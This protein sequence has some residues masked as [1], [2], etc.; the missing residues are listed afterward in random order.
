MNLY[1]TVFFL[2]MLTFFPVGSG[3]FIGETFGAF[4]ALGLTSLI[5]LGAYGFSD[6]VVLYLYNAK[7]LNE[8]EAQELFD[9]VKNLA[10][11]GGI[12]T[13]KV[14]L[15]NHATPNTFSTGR[16]P[17]HGSLIFTT[18]LLDLLN[19]KELSGI[20]GHELFH[21][22]QRGIFLSTVAA[23]VGGGFT[24][25]AGK[26]QNLLDIGQGVQKM[27]KK[28]F[29]AFGAFFFIILALMATFFIRLAHSSSREFLADKW[30]ARLCGNP[31]Y[32]ANA[33]G[34]IQNGR[35]DFPMMGGPGTA[36][37]FTMSP[38]SGKG[39]TSLFS[40]HPPLQTRLMKLEEMAQNQA[41][42]W[43]INNGLQVNGKI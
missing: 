1:K 30:G 15:I 18:G 39:L 35:E 37:M 27:G 29:G 9:M 32:L 7:E 25:L 20:I 40:T 19:Q 10:I 5:L 36:H 42:F 6:K 34:K 13:P 38:L 2:G 8:K 41:Y 4:F 16:N 23:V 11:R 3:F 17:K 22:Q 43:A 24:F 12:S 31:L 26:A 33:L 28:P 21:V 14:F